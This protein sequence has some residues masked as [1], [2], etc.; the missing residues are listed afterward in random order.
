M[1]VSGEI[2]G[3]EEKYVS[4]LPGY[5]GGGDAA[6]AAS[7]ESPSVFHS[8]VSVLSDWPESHRRFSGDNPLQRPRIEKRGESD[9]YGASAEGKDG[10]EADTARAVR[11]AVNG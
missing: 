10:G 8:I 7:N 6:I 4:S 11:Y 2:P 1:R 3:R 9:V 5:K